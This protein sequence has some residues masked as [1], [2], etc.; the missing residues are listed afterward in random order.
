MGTFRPY[1]ASFLYP[2]LFLDLNYNVNIS[3]DNS[4]VFFLAIVEKFETESVLLGN[5]DISQY[6]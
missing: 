4:G 3:L 6:F 2:P 5:I 1:L